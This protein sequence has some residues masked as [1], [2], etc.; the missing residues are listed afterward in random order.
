M[1]DARQPIDRLVQSERIKG[2]SRIIPDAAGSVTQEQA[3]AVIEAVREYQKRTGLRWNEIARAIG[4]RPSALSSLNSGRLHAITYWQ[5]LAIDLDLWLEQ[6]LKREAAPKPAQFV[7]TAVAEEVLTVAS[8]AATLKCIGLVFGPS[9]IGKSMALRAVAAEKPGTIFTS[10]KTAA[11]GATDV[12]QTIAAQLGIRDFCRMNRR[13]VMARIEEILKGT[14]RLIIV[15]EIHKLCGA[16]D[17]AGLHVLRDIYDATGVPMLWCGT[18]DVVAYLERAESKRGR[19]PLAQIRRR[20][21]I[22]RDL[23]ERTRGGPGGPG[24]PLFSVDEIRRVFARGK[25][26]ITPDAA[27]YLMMLANLPESGALGT[28]KN[29]MLMAQQINETSGA[30]ITLELLRSVHQLLV[31]RHDFKAMAARLE[32]VPTPRQTATVKAG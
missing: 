30:E 7:M 11:T 21:G 29:L 9:G 3:T 15:D 32:D 18:I 12:L 23:T 20:I 25:M 1:S 24:E 31:S 5:D 4:A 26:R 2:A 27:R 14:P 8:A 13:S 22:A 10:M 16:K 28:V 6:E 19:E 17:D